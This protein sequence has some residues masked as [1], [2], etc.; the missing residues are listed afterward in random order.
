MI[1]NITNY[2]LVVLILISLLAG[3]TVLCWSFG[4]TFIDTV[5]RKVVSMYVGKYQHRLDKS[6]DIL[7][8]D[9]ANGI[10][11]L[12]ALLVDLESIKVMDRLDPIKRRSLSLLTEALMEAKYFERALFW[13]EKWVEFDE[14]DL[15]AQAIRGKLVSFIPGREKEGIELLK[16]LFKRVPE[17]E[18]VAKTYAEILNKQEKYTEAFIVFSRSVSA[19][20]HE[21]DGSWV[22][23]WD[24][25]DGFKETNK[26]RFS[27]ELTL[28]NRIVLNVELDSDVKRLR[29][30]PPS[31]SKISIFDPKLFI[32]EGE[33][34]TTFHLLERPLQFNQMTRHGVFLKTSGG[35]DPYFY[36]QMPDPPIGEKLAISLELQVGLFFPEEMI[37]LALSPEGKSIEAELLARGENLE[38][39]QLRSIWQEETKKTSKTTMEQA[40]KILIGALAQA[41]VEIFWRS[42]GEDFSEEKKSRAL[43]VLNQATG[44]ME[45]NVF[46]PV[47]GKASELRLDFPDV[48]NVSYVLTQLEF[49]RGQHKQQVDVEKLSF[50]LQ[51]N[52]KKQGSFFEILG[53]DPYFSFKTPEFASNSDVHVMGVVR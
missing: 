6:Q 15:K 4:E 41:Y 25:G 23:Y 34:E 18:V 48:R 2:F 30:D 51:N 14:N 42:E 33:K 47:K 19:G 11:A 21:Y 28:D 49:V 17:A 26:K 43:M 27:P 3:A 36:W 53:L 8:K 31:F 7:K 20:R 40:N 5:D 29:I 13:A 38:V 12:E 24:L 9:S 39:E 35:N 16:N 44:G 37:Q 1:K 10:D 22:V 32:K 45:F 52:I 46:L 50:V